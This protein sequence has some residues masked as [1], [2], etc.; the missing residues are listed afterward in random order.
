MQAPTLPDLAQRLDRIDPNAKA[1]WGK[2]NLAQML[3]HCRM[4][5]ENA[6]GEMQVKPVD[7][8][9]TRSILFPLLMKLPWPKGKAAT[10]QEFDVVK[11]NL[12]VR[13]VAEE[14]AALAG[15]LNVVMNGGFQ[16]K[17]HAIFGPLSM[18]K[19]IGL[20]RKHLDHHFRQFGV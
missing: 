18:E 9:L 16:P 20:Q 6:L 3:V 4:P 1:L 5:I 7:N 12:P 14:A 10:H 2:M 19:W 11:L 17:P 15:K 13:T 8:F